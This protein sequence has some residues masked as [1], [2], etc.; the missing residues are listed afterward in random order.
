MPLFAA[1]ICSVN[2]TIL[3]LSED[4]DSKNQMFIH[5]PAKYKTV[6]RKRRL[7]FEG[8][9]YP[10]VSSILSATKPVSDRLALQRWRRRVGVQQAQKISIEACRRGTSVHTAINYFLDG[11]DLPDDVEDNLYWQSIKPVLASVDQVYLLESAVY[12]DEHQYAGLFDCLGEW[13][14]DLCVFDWKTA[15]KP[16]KIDWITDYCLQV[17][18][19]TAAINHL[20]QVQI[21]Q[22]IIAIALEDRPAQLFQLN[23]Q[24]LS[25]Y[26]SQFLIR[27]RLWSEQQRV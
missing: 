8:Q 4:V 12:H 5:I 1:T 10:S 13:Q 16:K 25:N 6:N 21:D 7:V 2:I 26:W 24:D 27:L 19:Y 3:F 23:A 9:A 11:R 17:T 15:A 18:A 14:G 20:Y 22:A